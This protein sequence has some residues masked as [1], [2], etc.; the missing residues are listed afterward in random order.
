[1]PE[2]AIGTNLGTARLTA[3]VQEGWEPP[4]ALAHHGS[5]S[6]EPQ[7]PEWRAIYS[8][9]DV[10]VVLERQLGAGTVV[11][12]ADSYSVSNEALR[13][14]R[15]PGWL[16]WL[17]GRPGRIVFDERH[18]GVEE[19]TGVVTLARRYRLHGFGVG[20]L[21]IAAL[22]GWRAL[23]PL[24]PRSASNGLAGEDPTV[25]GRDSSFGLQ[26]LFERRVQRGELP[27]LCLEAWRASF[28]VEAKRL[29]ERGDRMTTVVVVERNRPAAERDPLAAYR[30]LSAL[31]NPRN[32]RDSSTT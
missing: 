13:R 31:A 23:M 24:V 30:E 16:S 2:D 6:L 29:G 25:I 26:T 15:E 11:I 18:L 21:L 19:A 9:G 7:S 8:V 3:E 32:R 22:W 27:A 12:C 17:V 1:M 4:E 5:W 28:P 14:A 20:L 10:P